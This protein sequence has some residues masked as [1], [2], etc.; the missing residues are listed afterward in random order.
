MGGLVLLSY[1]NTN[2][3][4]T[5][6]IRR[7]CLQLEQAVVYISES[8]SE[9]LMLNVGPARLMLNFTAIFLFLTEIH[10]FGKTNQE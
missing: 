3:A 6:G 7:L 5:F 8:Q 2:S 10:Y 1:F 4:L 9:L